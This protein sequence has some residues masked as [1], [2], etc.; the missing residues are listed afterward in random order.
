MKKVK[1]KHLRQKSPIEK[2]IPRD[3]S[4]PKH[5]AYL[6]EPAQEKFGKYKNPEKRKDAE[7]HTDK[8]Y[9]R[10]REVVNRMHSAY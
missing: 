1:H 6:F 10:V 2:T 5:V 3:F 4:V 9:N 7:S 8:K